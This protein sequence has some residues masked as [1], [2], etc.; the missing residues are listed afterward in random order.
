MLTSTLSQSNWNSYIH[1]QKP[2]WNAAALFYTIGG[3]YGGIFLLSAQAIALNALG[4][5]LV[6]HALVLSA[7]LAHELMHG[8]FFSSIKTNHLWGAL[9]QWLHGTSYARFQDLAQGHIDHHMKGVDLYLFDR[10]AFIN[11]LPAPLKRLIAALEWLYFPALFFIRQAAGVG[12]IYQNGTSATKIRVIAVLLLRVAMFAAFGWFS[13]KGL[14]LYSLAYVGAVQIISIMDCLQHT[15]EL[16]PYDAVIPK[17]SLAYEQSHTFSTPISRRYPWLNLL[18]LNFSYHNAHHAAM[19]CPWYSLPHLDAAIT[20]QQDI[21]HISLLQVLT[22]YHRFRVQR[23][24]DENEGHISFDAEG[25]PNVDRFYG[26]MGG[27]SLLLA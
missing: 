14:L 12:L 26:V 19:K 5:F 4:I 18:L 8:T 21:C 13:P 27:T 9:M 23:L 24:F 2:L 3:Y 16:H 17:K 7:Y 20:Q 25:N 11:R 22:N 6:T 15:Y 1:Q 10:I